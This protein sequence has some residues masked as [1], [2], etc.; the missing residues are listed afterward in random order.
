MKPNFFKIPKLLGGLSGTLVFGL[1]S[2]LVVCIGYMFQGHLAKSAPSE[3]VLLQMLRNDESMKKIFVD[4]RNWHLSR[5]GTMGIST[6]RQYGVYYFEGDGPQGK[7]TV[8]VRWEVGPNGV[9][10]IDVH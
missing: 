1:V 2:I 5:I 4:G 3:A 9:K 8:C 6:K 10:I 7:E